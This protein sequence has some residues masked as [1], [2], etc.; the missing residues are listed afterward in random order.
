MQTAFCK[1]LAAPLLV[2][3]GFCAFG[4]VATFE[5]MPSVEQWTWR[6]V[7][8]VMGI[9]CLYATAR[10]WRSTCKSPSARNA[11]LARR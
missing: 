4:F 1:I 3:A 10:L 6:V 7:Y 5:P 2:L 9:S 11:S 8:V